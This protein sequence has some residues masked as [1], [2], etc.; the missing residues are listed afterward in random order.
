MGGNASSCRKVDTYIEQ[1]N[2]ISVEDNVISNLNTLNCDQSSKMKMKSIKKK[3]WK[4]P[5]KK[6][7][8]TEVNIAEATSDHPYSTYIECVIGE[9]RSTHNELV[10][11]P[12]LRPKLNSEYEKQETPHSCIM[13]SLYAEF[14]LFQEHELIEYKLKMTKEEETIQKDVS[15]METESKNTT[16]VC[17]ENTE[18]YSTEKILS[19]QNGY[20]TLGLS[21]MDTDTEISALEDDDMLF[22]HEKMYRLSEEPEQQLLPYFGNSVPQMLN[23][24]IPNHKMFD[25]ENTT[26]KQVY[27][28]PDEDQD[29][30]VSKV[31]S[32]RLRGVMK[33][34][35]YPDTSEYS[36]V[37]RTSPYLSSESSISSLDPSSEESEEHQPS[38]QQDKKDWQIDNVVHYQDMRA[39]QK[40]LIEEYELDN[41]SSCFYDEHFPTPDSMKIDTPCDLTK[42]SETDEGYLCQNV[43]GHD[44][45]ENLVES[46]SS[47]KLC[48]SETIEQQVK[49]QNKIPITSESKRE[50]V[51][52]EEANGSD[53]LSTESKPNNDKVD[54]NILDTKSNNPERIET[55]ICDEKKRGKD[56]NSNTNPSFTKMDKSEEIKSSHKP[57]RIVE[58][59][60][61]DATSFLYTDVHTNMLPFDENEKAEAEIDANNKGK[62]EIKMCV[63]NEEEKND[64]KN[65]D[66]ENKAKENDSCQSEVSVTDSLIGATCPANSFVDKNDK[67]TKHQKNDPEK[68]QD[69]SCNDLKNVHVNNHPKSDGNNT[70]N[71]E[72]E[73]NHQVRE[74]NFKSTNEEN[75]TKNINE[76][77]LLVNDDMEQSKNNEKETVQP[78]A[79]PEKT[80]NNS[81]KGK[82]HTSPTYE[83]LEEAVHTDNV[84]SDNCMRYLENKISLEHFRWK[85]KKKKKVARKRR[86]SIE[87]N[88]LSSGEF[89]S[90]GKTT[91][92]ES[93]PRPM[94][95][96]SGISECFCKQCHK[97]L[98]RQ[99]SHKKSPHG[100]L[101]NHDNIITDIGHL[102]TETNTVKV[103]SGIFSDYE[104]LSNE[105]MTLHLSV[106]KTYSELIQ[107]QKRLQIRT[108]EGLKN[109][110]QSHKQIKIIA[111][112]IRLQRKTLKSLNKQ[113]NN[114]FSQLNETS[115]EI[116][117]SLSQFIPGDADIIV[118][119]GLK[120]YFERLRNGPPPSQEEQ[121]HYEWF[122]F[123]SFH[124]YTG[125]GSAIVLAR[126]GFYHDSARG[127]TETRCFACGVRYSTWS[128]FDDIVAIHRK[129]SPN[130]PHIHG[131]D[132]ETRNVSITQDEPRQERMT[133]SPM[134]RSG[135]GDKAT[136]TAAAGGDTGGNIEGATQG[137]TG[138]PTSMEARVQNITEQMKQAHM[139][140]QVSNTQ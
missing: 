128:E 38:V 131:H 69:V 124:Q 107:T 75:S 47:L 88:S 129:L 115:K 97:N 20:K 123:S 82:M 83:R 98:N 96:I 119:P 132:A 22:V 87:S 44:C 66:K 105:Y 30:E 130:C 12:Q 112:E 57:P 52:N 95:K 118:C 56:V 21:S 73:D 33:S 59:I 111:N 116:S 27:N 81:K 49:Q 78:I 122:R 58:I 10:V 63:L 37:N 76:N 136:V 140:Q 137:A 133:A 139:I 108:E 41:K 65:Q 60:E 42:Y 6:K 103:D 24:S 7:K 92:K 36:T 74:R 54:K 17:Y 93:L 71:I 101:Q 77:P 102:I 8:M 91:L 1:E 104:M 3:H 94:P 45:N 40:S 55:K 11:P 62:D 51:Q 34:T 121:M 67:S 18:N 29:E 25:S 5:W 53:Y 68:T 28:Y 135:D 4:L 16:N 72:K 50:P 109:K 9:K 114:I 13:C 39:K 125:N 23:I 48:E 117:K 46:G 2:L 99:C 86:V 84:L 127:C 100:E 26:V 138:G 61:T 113:Q 32:F 120:G 35:G 80:E 126:N 89:E 85:T 106:R 110:K 19:L 31:N 43:F 64:G 15:A 79:I 90:F 134:N 70:L 14:C